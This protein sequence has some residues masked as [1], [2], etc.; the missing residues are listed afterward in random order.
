MW[1]AAGVFNANGDGAWASSKHDNTDGG[2]W[3]I[4]PIDG[5]K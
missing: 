3:L 5:Q 4:T 1:P 2:I